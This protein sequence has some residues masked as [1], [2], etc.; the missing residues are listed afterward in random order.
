[1]AELSHELTAEVPSRCWAEIELSAIR[2]NARVAQAMCGTDAPSVLAIIKADAYGH[3]A[4]A[5]GRA[6]QE[7][8]CV[9]AFGVANVHEA[10][11]LHD[12][13]IRLPVY[14]LS[15]ALPSERTTVVANGFIAAVSNMEEAVDY[16]AIACRMSTVARIQCVL[17]TGMGRIGML[18]DGILTFA[19]DLAA[20]PAIEIESV[21]SHLPSAD[22]DEHFTQDQMREYRRLITKLQEKGI[23]FTRSHIANSAGTMGYP[24][25]SNECVRAGLMLYGCAPVSKFQ[26]HLKPALTLKACVTLVRN[27]P[28]GQSISYGRTFI[29]DRPTVTATISAGYADGYPRHLSGQGAEVLI[30]GRRCPLLGRVTMDQI[31]VDVTDLPKRPEVGCEVVLLGSQNMESVLAQEVADKAGTI[32]WEIFTGISKR[33]HRVVK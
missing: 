26:D 5:V 31:V 18:P 2:H 30:H 25:A 27:L 33:V 4:V 20:L 7:E 15:P 17:D 21:S 11:E 8:S 16:S 13:N 22:E 24:V 32:P 14:V 23:P 10:L 1:M 6:L 28:E 29:T 19:Q 12:A 3:G 9:F